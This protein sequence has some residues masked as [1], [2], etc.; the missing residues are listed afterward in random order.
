MLSKQSQWK[1]KE[2]RDSITRFFLIRCEKKIPL[3]LSLPYL[4]QVR[5][6]MCE[7]ISLLMITGM[8]LPF[9]LKRKKRLSL[10]WWR[11]SKWRH[12]FTLTEDESVHNGRGGQT[13]QHSSGRER[14]RTPHSTFHQVESGRLRTVLPASRVIVVTIDSSNNGCWSRREETRELLPPVYSSFFFLLPTPSLY[15]MYN[16]E[17]QRARAPS[18]KHIP[19]WPSLTLLLERRHHHSLCANYCSLRL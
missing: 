18:H 3:F 4:S 10:L 17:R 2:S 19:P 8:V 11:L 6:Y 13:P 15:V 16:G 7:A 1:Q 12:A 9:F 5:T 14:T